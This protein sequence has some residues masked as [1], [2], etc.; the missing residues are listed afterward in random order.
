MKRTLNKSV[1]VK[2]NFASCIVFKVEKLKCVSAG[3]LPW[4]I[5]GITGGTID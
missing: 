5:S 4:F 2:L 3:K 1:R